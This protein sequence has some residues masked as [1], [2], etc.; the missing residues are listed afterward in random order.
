MKKTTIVLFAL[1]AIF[2]ATSAYLAFQNSDIKAENAKITAEKDAHKQKA[3]EI[4]DLRA[5]QAIAD[6]AL[7]KATEKNRTLEKELA[8]AGNTSVKQQKA[9]DDSEK[10]I[11]ALQKAVAEKE[12]EAQAARGNAEK[13]KATIEELQKGLA[14]ANA[15]TEELNGE[16]VKMRSAQDRQALENTIAEKDQTIAELSKERDLL[17]EE[18]SERKMEVADLQQRLEAQQVTASD[19][20]AAADSRVAELQAELDEAKKKI[21][22]LEQKNIRLRRRAANF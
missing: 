15:R 7:V 14:E 3:D 13:D 21:A 2:A 6:E 1:A 19:Q 17:D 8:E 10:Q 16:V 22:D 9:L 12:N 4:Y 18:L 11:A 20:T 5:K